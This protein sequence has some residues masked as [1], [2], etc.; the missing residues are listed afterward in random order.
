MARL[1]YYAPG[2]YVEEVLSAR[3]PIAGVGTNTAGFIGIVPDV[4]YI[5]MPNPEYDPVLT[6]DLLAYAKLSAQGPRK[7]PTAEDRRKKDLD[8]LQADLQARLQVLDAEIKALSDQKPD[9]DKAVETAEGEL[10]RANEDQAKLDASAT[11]QQTADA[12]RAVRAAQK[13]ATTAKTDASNT[14][15]VLAQKQADRKDIGDQ[16]DA[17]KAAAGGAAAVP[18]AA[19]GAAGAPAP[20]AAPNAAPGGIVETELE[21]YLGADPP[22]ALLQKSVL[23]PYY[24]VPFEVAADEFATKLC[25]NFSEYAHLFGDF[26]AFGPN[27]NGQIAPLRPGHH[28]LTHAVNGFFTNGGTRAFVARVRGVEGLAKALDRFKSIDDVAILAAPGLPKITDV[29]EA[30]ES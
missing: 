26:S 13:K 19:G 8:S 1:A 15:S 3:Q 17:A 20:A 28:L 22:P 5:P 9:Q 2:V 18:A 23:R 7:D 12:T 24:L 10:T 4:V 6:S 21:D 14:A 27:A 29:W 16:L 25:T 30:L 11:P